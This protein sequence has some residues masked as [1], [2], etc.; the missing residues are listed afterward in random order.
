MSDPIYVLPGDKNYFSVK[1]EDNNDPARKAT[2]ES[3][4][5]HFNRFDP[6]P[7]RPFLSGIAKLAENQT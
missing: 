6:P 5:K 1:Y 7:E 3:G 4:W 2:L